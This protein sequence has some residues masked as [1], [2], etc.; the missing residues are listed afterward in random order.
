[1]L[2]KTIIIGKKEK[3]CDEAANGSKFVGLEGAIKIR[4]PTLSWQIKVERHA[5][6]YTNTAP[7]NPSV[8]IF[9][10]LYFIFLLILSPLPSPTL[11]Y[12]V[13]SSN[14]V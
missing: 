10:I 14:Q 1:M 8:S 4:P 12:P 7:P 11:S 3:K 6:F 13:F 5:P 2:S 9:L